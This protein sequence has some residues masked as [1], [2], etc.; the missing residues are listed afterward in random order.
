MQAREN[1]VL[2][3]EKYRPAK[4]ADVVLAPETK[5][6]FQGFVN[7]GF[8]PNLTAAGL[9]GVGK[10]TVLIAALE[11]VGADWVKINGSLS[12]NI[13]T[14]RN[15]IVDFASAVSLLGTRKYVLFDEA[16]YLNPLSTQ[17]AL[18]GVIE[19]F[20]GNCGFVLTCNYK[21]RLIEPILSRC[22]PIEFKAP[23]GKAKVH[24]AV[25]FLKRVTEILKAEGVEFDAQVVATVIQRTFP[26]FRKAINQLQHYSNRAGKID[27]GMLSKSESLS[28]KEL[29]GY[30]K[31]K[32]FTN[33]RMWVAENSEVEAPVLYN[34]L[35]EGCGEWLAPSSVPQCILFLSE[36]SHRAVM[37]SDPEVHLTAC[38]ANIMANC[39]FK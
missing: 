19:E 33:A 20:S 18:R 15:D 22:P 14:L 6:V 17:P 37:G 16:D 10:T 38:I 9:P 11:E 29:I 28:V 27:A 5:E 1:E 23:I 24:L 39:V 35:F 3:S 12:G 34:K 32:N 26:D 2:W 21:T 13:D 7:N 30:M 31:D 4:V 8:V 36:Y 25:E